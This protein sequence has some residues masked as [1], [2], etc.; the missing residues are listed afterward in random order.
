MPTH[1]KEV[2]TEPFRLWQWNCRSYRQKRGSL[3]QF[4]Q[5][6]AHIP[7]ILA[8]QETYVEPKLAGYT[9]FVYTGSHNT[10]IK[11]ATLV[12]NKL[13]VIDHTLSTERIP[14]VLTEILPADRNKSSFF[15]LN[16]Y[17]AP[18]ERTDSFD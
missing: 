7:D 16:V 17:S 11:A 9:S 13:T 10:P 4:I 1:K 2:Q 15:V 5:A 8:L 14:H 3:T 12:S 6:Q 18:K